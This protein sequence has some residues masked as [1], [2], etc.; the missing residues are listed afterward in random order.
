VALRAPGRKREHGIEPIQGLDGAL[1]IPGKD[2]GVGRRLR[3]EADDVGRFGLEIRIIA[4]PVA[5]HP[6]GLHSGALPDAGD[7]RMAHLEPSR[8]PPRAPVGGA[9]G[10]SQ[11]GR[12][13]NLALQGRSAAQNFA[14]T[15]AR[16]ES[17]DALGQKASLP[18]RH[19]LAPTAQTP[20][21]S[22]VGL[23]RGQAQN[24]IRPARLV[25]A[26]PTRAH[27]GAQ[28]SSL[29][30]TQFHPSFPHAVRL[31]HDSLIFNDTL[32]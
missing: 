28:D 20:L 7:H 29:G 15:M 25:R 21:Q 26:H 8:Q 9:V 19:I 31:S 1:F 6:V 17:S 4:R 16:I 18:P 3:V 24:Q 12:G 27:F 13:Q 14:A 2:R 5:T 30:R 23:S 32:H 10:R 22:A 11:A